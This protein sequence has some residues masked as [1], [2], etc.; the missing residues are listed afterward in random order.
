MTSARAIEYRITRDL[1]ERDINFHAQR[2][3]RCAEHL[4][5]IVAAAAG[6]LLF[7]SYLPELVAA[8]VAGS[9]VWVLGHS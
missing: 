2:S 9:A 8:G 5:A 3:H 4:I 6:L 7:G 1:M